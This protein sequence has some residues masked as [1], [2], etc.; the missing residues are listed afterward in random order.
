M[1]DIQELINKY[2]D[3][4]LVHENESPN[5]N[6]QILIFNDGEIMDTKGGS[7]FLQRSMFSLEP[8]LSGANTKMPREHGD[9]SF[10]IV[11]TL[12]KALEIRNKMAN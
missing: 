1:S 8:P 11:E 5:G 10:A 2:H 4:S 3:P 9:Y 12:E 6:R 7:A